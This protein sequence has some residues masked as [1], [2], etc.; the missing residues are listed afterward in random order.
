MAKFECKICGSK[1]ELAKHT[2]KVEDGVIVSPDA[3]CCK[4]Y[5]TGIRENAGLG[6]I[7]KRPGGTVSG[8]I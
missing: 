1:L 3:M 6:G 2:I 7:I 5:M 8:K 4:T